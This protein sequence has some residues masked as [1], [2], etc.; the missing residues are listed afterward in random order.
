MQPQVKFLLFSY[1]GMQNASITVGDNSEINVS[2]QTSAVLEEVVV[3]GYGT[4]KKSD[5]ISSVSSVKPEDLTK[6]ATSDIGEMLRGKAAGVLVTLANGGPGSSSNILI[7]GQNSINGGNSPIIIVDGV[8]VGNINDINANDIASMEILKDAASQSIYGACA[9]NGVIL[10]T[11]K[12]GKEG[13]N[14]SKLQ[15]S[16]RNPDNQQK[17]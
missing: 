1:L 6:V 3:V 12:R 8:P 4:T 17:F 15:W 7:R 10:I 16:F 5:V 9:S 13:K 2:L 11:T 14:E